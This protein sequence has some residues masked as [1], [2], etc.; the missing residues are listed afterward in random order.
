MGN[1]GSESA[2]P[3]WLQSL[4]DE[5]ADQAPLCHNIRELNLLAQESK[6]WSFTEFWRPGPL[7]D[8]P[9]HARQVWLKSKAAISEGHYQ[10]LSF[11]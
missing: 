5:L 9:G 6:T 7:L 1:G 11:T 3:C 2:A 4:Q 10:V 8:P